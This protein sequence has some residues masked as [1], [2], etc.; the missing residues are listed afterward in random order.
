MDGGFAGAG[1]EH[2]SFNADAISPRSNPYFT[3]LSK[4]LLSSPGQI[5]SLFHIELDKPFAVLYFKKEHFPP[6]VDAHDTTGH[7]DMSKLD[8]FVSSVN[9]SLI[10]VE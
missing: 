10:S 3:T 5:S 7:G 4:K 6:I 9:A 2:E 8:P 1:D